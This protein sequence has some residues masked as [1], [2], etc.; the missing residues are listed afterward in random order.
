M[1]ITFYAG[2]KLRASDL[3]GLVD[4]HIRKAK[5]APGTA[6]QSTTTLTADPDLVLPLQANYTYMIHGVMYS[7]SPASADIQ[8]AISF[9]ALATATFGASRLATS[10]AAATGD[11]DWGAY[12]S[13]TSGVSAIGVGGTGGVQYTTISSTVV[14]GSTAGDFTI[15][16]AQLASVASDTTL[17]GGSWIAGIRER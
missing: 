6:R 5:P 9:P 3:Q 12:D 13:A 1:T 11:G 17:E 2:Q 15:M 10:V 14:M 8:F 16:W 7:T 4:D